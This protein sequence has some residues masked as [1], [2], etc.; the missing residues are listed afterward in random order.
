MDVK[1][2][3]VDDNALLRYGL[4]DTINNEDGMSVV[5]EA[6]NGTEALE[7]YRA[8]K[9]DVVTMDYR[10]PNEDGLEASRKILAEFPE[11]K[12]IFLSI[13]EGDEDVWNAWKVGV[14][15][16]LSKTNA[17]D[18]I[19]DAIS[20]LS[21]GGRYFPASMVEKVEF[22][23]TQDELTPREMEVLDL[24]VKG[25]SNKEIAA[26]FGISVSTVK[27]HISKLLE[28]LGAADRTQAVIM[29]L[30]RGFV[31]LDS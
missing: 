23:K 5:G 20:E 8:L 19:L 11:A 14:C 3:V 26:S 24:M 21:K 7:Q 30:K 4:R 25:Q 1:V 29:A 6:A 12:I 2:L 15:G 17:A 16:Y 22:R 28:K 18:E 27:H 31:H 9:P 10:M 13:C